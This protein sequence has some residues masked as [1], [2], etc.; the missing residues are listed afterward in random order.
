MIHRMHNKLRLPLAQVSDQRQGN[1]PSPRGYACTTV[2][3]RPKIFSFKNQKVGSCNGRC[4]IK[5]GQN[6]EA[7]YYSAREYEKNHCRSAATPLSPFLNY[8]SNTN[9][10][11]DEE[12]N[13]VEK[14]LFIQPKGKQYKIITANLNRHFIIYQDFYGSV[15]NNPRI[16]F[17]LLG[18]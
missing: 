7:P 16:S 2:I 4:S 8:Y 3:S 15:I 6:G 17:K 9:G 14:I 10:R 5:P 11:A 12:F 13:F 1:D 18:I